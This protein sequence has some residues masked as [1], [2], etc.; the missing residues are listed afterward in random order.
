MRPSTFFG[1]ALSFCTIPTLTTALD[2]APANWTNATAAASLGIAKFV[3]TSQNT[4]NSGFMFHLVPLTNNA[5]MSIATTGFAAPAYLLNATSKPVPS[6]DIIILSC[7]PEDYPAGVQATSI[8]N[9]NGKA[10]AA[11]LYSRTSDYC[12][13]DYTFQGPFFTTQN[14]SDAIYLVKTFDTLTT[15]TT[16]QPE[17]TFL[18]LN[19]N[20]GAPSNQVAMIILYSITGIITALFL[21]VIV[22]GGVRARR[23]PERYGPM[24]GV[25]GARQSRA[26]GLARAVLDTLPIVRFGDREGD[27]AARKPDD[28][29]LAQPTQH[30]VVEAYASQTG[31]D[32]VVIA[33]TTKSAPAEKTSAVDVSQPQPAH[34]REVSGIADAE[35]TAPATE[36]IETQGCS[37]CTDDFEVGQDQ[38]V[39]PCNHRFHPACVDPWL[40]NVSGTCPLCR[41]DLTGGQNG[42]PRESAEEGQ[43]EGGDQTVLPLSMRDAS[44]AEHGRSPRHGATL[45]ARMTREERLNAL[46][47]MRRQHAADSSPAETANAAEDEGRLR[48]RL[49]SVFHI[50]T[51]RTGD[52][53]AE[54]RDAARVPG[55]VD[56]AAVPGAY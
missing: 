56:S 9:N 27:A 49:R 46:R 54:H 23:H 15:N 48:R 29:E 26:R 42:A 25:G 4:G 7:D 12:R 36:Q 53:D 52:D 55:T 22:I 38:R 50:R 18:G 14:A 39:L 8:L 41:I 43:G 34:D 6:E 5:N 32:E 33:P 51:R 40:L 17:G 44:T 45:I 16:A 37:I 1:A 20:P 11:I 30:G 3:L 2:I 31:H 21:S 47:N 10:Y 24:G 19:L 35:T 28:I 13:Y